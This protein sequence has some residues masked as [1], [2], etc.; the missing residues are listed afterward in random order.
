L[1]GVGAEPTVRYGPAAPQAVAAAAR[2]SAWCWSSVPESLAPALTPLSD[3]LSAR[4]RQ[5][6]LRMRSEQ[7]VSDATPEIAARKLRDFQP[8]TE[9][10]R[11]SV[12]NLDPGSALDQQAWDVIRALDA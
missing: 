8:P 11:D 1:A 5:R 2:V 7:R 9:L 4:P 12:L 3:G 10:P 6:S